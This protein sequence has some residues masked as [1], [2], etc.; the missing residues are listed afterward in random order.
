MSHSQA[1]CDLTSIVSEWFV[2]CRLDSTIL[3]QEQFYTGYGFYDV[4]TAKAHQYP[5]KLLRKLFAER[6]HFGIAATRTKP[7]RYRNK[8]W[9]Q[10]YSFGFFFQSS[11]LLGA[12][13]YINISLSRPEDAKFCFSQHDSLLQTFFKR[14]FNDSQISRGSFD[15]IK[16]SVM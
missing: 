5:A 14:C 10:I 6:I 11:G 3:V 8:N 12:N 7:I 1:K 13:V 2:D 15:V 9:G 4:P 16:T